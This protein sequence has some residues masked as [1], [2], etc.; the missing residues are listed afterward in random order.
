MITCEELSNV[1]LIKV[2]NR[3]VVT[4]GQSKVSPDKGGENW[5]KLYYPKIEGE[6]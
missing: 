6:K 3:M 4:E 5:I 2:Q 1:G